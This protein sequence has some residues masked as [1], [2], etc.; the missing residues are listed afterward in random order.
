[1]SQSDYKIGLKKM[2]KSVCFIEYFERVKQS[3]T[4]L[5]LAGKVRMN[6]Y[7]DKDECPICLTLNKTLEE[8]V[9]PIRCHWSSNIVPAVDL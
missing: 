6:T 9:N 1:M 7:D 4:C 5:A 2:D 8:K 3:T